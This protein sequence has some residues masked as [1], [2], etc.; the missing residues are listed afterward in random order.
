MGHVDV[1]RNATVLSRVLRF[2]VWGIGF[3]DKSRH[4]DFF[5]TAVG[6]VYKLKIW[7]LGFGG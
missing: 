7:G 6:F 3:I 4:P 5:E 2:R 1:A